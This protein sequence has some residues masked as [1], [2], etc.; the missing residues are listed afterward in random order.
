MLKNYLKENN[1]QFIDEKEKL[2]IYDYDAYLAKGNASIV[3]SP[4]TMNELSGVIDYLNR[5]NMKYL[6]RG[7]GTNYCGG[8]QAQHHDVVVSIAQ[9]N[10]EIIELDNNLY[11]ISPSVK[12]AEIN[13][14]LMEKSLVYPPDPASLRV[15]TL[16]GT[17]AMNAGG[18]RCYMYGV[19]ANYIREINVNTPQHGTINL[20]SKQSYVLPNYPVKHLF[21]GSEGTLGTVLNA[22]VSTQKDNL[23]KS[24]LIIQ[25]LDY[26]HAIKAVDIIV[27]EGLLT[28]AIDMS[29]DPFIPGITNQIGAKLIISIEHDNEE[30]VLGKLTTLKEAMDQFD[31]QII[32]YGTLH[33]MRLAVVQENVQGVIKRSNKKVYFL[34]DTVVP[35]SKLEEIIEYFFRLSEVFNFPILNTYHAGDGNIHPTIFYDP[36]DE[37]EYEKLKLFLHLIITK[38]VR[39]GG[40]VTG[41][42]GIGIEKKNIQYILTDPRLNKLYQEIKQTFDQENIINVGKLLSDNESVEQYK[43]LVR[44]YSLKYCYPIEKMEYNSVKYKP[45]V[46]DG[47]LDIPAQLSPRELFDKLE[48]ETISIPYFPVVN[49]QLSLNDLYKLGIPSFLDSIYNLDLLTRAVELESEFI[50]GRKTLKNVEGYNVVPLYLALKDA[51][52][53]TLKTVFKEELRN[54]YYF[55][56]TCCAKDEVHKWTN[57]PSFR[58]FLVDYYY[59]SVGELLLLLSCKVEIP[60]NFEEYNV[61]SGTNF[62]EYSTFYII[63]LDRELQFEDIHF[64]S[65]L[66]LNN[67][68]TLLVFD[69]IQE[70]K[71]ELLKRVSSSIR[72]I[73]QNT[74][75]YIYLDQ[76]Y[77]KQ[78]DILND[79][80]RLIE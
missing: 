44:E 40:A 72:K 77:K 52:T 17:I 14:K 76:R 9:L 38:A 28:T 12:L 74:N 25:F 60:S 26:K 67:E 42:H 32:S 13:Q 78:V 61:W 29:T 10:K 22:T 27:K 45:S 8:V 59:T 68:K 30:I 36:T 46:E 43:G 37:E 3:I 19:T 79:L 69:T 63:S 2:F 15:C 47:V 11:T 70:Q 66:Y 48:E 7:A 53:V 33:D 57:H 65:W 21:I 34:F 41:E 64:N 4:K 56:K 23:Y 73:N 18:A 49:S 58:N 39:L 80:K 6:I 54:K 75:E 55:I 24:E 16:G 71:M 1:V 31:C 20:G 62:G 5:N 35:R 50:V 51:K